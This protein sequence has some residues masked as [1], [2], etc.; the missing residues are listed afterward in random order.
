MSRLT[1]H[2]P[3]HWHDAD[4]KHRMTDL[5]KISGWAEQFW[6]R[7]EKEYVRH[8]EAHEDEVQNPEPQ[9]GDP[10]MVSTQF[11]W[12]EHYEE[13]IRTTRQLIVA[14]RQQAAQAPDDDKEN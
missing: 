14:L 13:M 10:P 1:G 5:R 3:K 6:S 9:P 7:D 11:A 2:E 12:I 4:G 8:L